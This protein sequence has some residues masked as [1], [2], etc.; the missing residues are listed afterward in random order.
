MKAIFNFKLKF[1]PGCGRKIDF[2][3]EKAEH[4]YRRGNVFICV[5]TTEFEYVSPEKMKE[6]FSDPI[7]EY[8][9][10]KENEGMEKVGWVRKR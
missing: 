5:C 2:D 9:L 6:I 8:I 7:E 3:G 1:C 10:Y 4:D